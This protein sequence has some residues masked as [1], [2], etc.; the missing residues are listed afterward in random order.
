MVVI[1]LFVAFIVSQFVRRIVNMRS[2]I[3]G[4]RKMSHGVTSE[5]AKVEAHK[6]LNI[7]KG[8]LFCLSFC[9]L[10][11]RNNPCQ[12]SGMGVLCAIWTAYCV[13]THEHLHHPEAAYSYL[14]IRNKPYPWKECPDCNLLDNGCWDECRKNAAH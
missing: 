7:S 12:F 11:F 13:A 6:W 14:K 1:T 8:L 3:A 9:D 2:A 4:A 5:E 10:D